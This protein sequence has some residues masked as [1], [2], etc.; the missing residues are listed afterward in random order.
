MQKQNLY[1]MEELVPVMTSFFAEGKKVMVTA[2]GNSMLPLIRNRK[3]SIVLT[4]YE[5]SQLNIGD[6]VF[7]KR[8]DGKY[9]LHRI[10]DVAQDGSFIILGDNQTVTEKGI[11]KDQIIALPTA[12]IRG[13]KTV[14]VTSG[15]YLRYKK[16][17]T[18]SVVLRKLHEKYFNL[19]NRIVKKFKRT[20]KI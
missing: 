2:V 7:Y 10:V 19:K 9:V 5:G 6:M 13:K 20:F 1:S 14:S 17:W 15:E 8:K 11:K 12:I 18:R 4:A 3:D 16:I